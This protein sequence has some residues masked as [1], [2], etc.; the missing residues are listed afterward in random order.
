MYHTFPQ[1]DPRDVTED[2]SLPTEVLHLCYSENPR[3]LPELDGIALDRLGLIQ[4]D[5]IPTVIR[6]AQAVDIP[7]RSCPHCDDATYEN[8]RIIGM[9]HHKQ[10]RASHTLF[11]VL[12]RDDYRLRPQFR[13]REASHQPVPEDAGPARL[14]AAMVEGAVIA[15]MRRLIAT[16]EIAAQVL[17]RFQQESFHCDQREL[18]AALKSFHGLWE[19]LFPAERARIVRLLVARV[20]VSPD[21]MAIDLRHQGLG[22][23][24][25]ELLAKRADGVAA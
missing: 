16:P 7:T 4:A 21:G 25:R 8:G 6:H 11:K 17:E 5:R 10:E 20:T 23:L 12:L 14:P 15:E 9:G 3:R 2:V 1:R 22:I 18:V 13:D 24:T 19:V